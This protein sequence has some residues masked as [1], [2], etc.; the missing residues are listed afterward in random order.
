MRISL[1]FFLIVIEATLHKEVFMVDLFNVGKGDMYLNMKLGSLKRE[2][3]LVIRFDGMDSQVTCFSREGSAY[4]VEDSSS[5][6]PSVSCGDWCGTC[7][8]GLCVE[9]ENKGKIGQ[10]RGEFEC[11]EKE[12]LIKDFRFNFSCLENSTTVRDPPTKRQGWVSLA[13][14][15]TADLE[16]G[17]QEK[18]LNK[19][20]LIDSLY[21]TGNIRYPSVVFCRGI[22][23]HAIVFGLDQWNSEFQEIPVF[24]S[25]I[26]KND[27]MSLKN[28]LSS[29]KIGQLDIEIGSPGS[30][31][32]K[33]DLKKQGISLPI[34]IF[35]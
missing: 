20:S 7:E 22:L 27:F 8:A 31:N 4:R 19:G 13:R 34:V 6:K 28:G 18:E 30:T 12:A 17:A 1:C 15:S 29:F 32:I 14:Y 2:V 23:N 24:R 21:G 33:I 5:Y 26:L 11:L 9:K 3:A 35:E 16:S 10:D 25:E